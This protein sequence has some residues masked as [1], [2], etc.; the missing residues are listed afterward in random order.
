[1]LLASIS[2]VLAICGAALI[3]VFATSGVSIAEQRVAL[4]IGNGAY[5]HTTTLKNPSNDAAAIA[6][7]L[8]RLG[9]KVLEGRDLT[10]A[11]FRDQLSDFSETLSQ[12]ETALFFYAGHAIQVDL[13][14]W[15]IPV[16]AQIANAIDLELRAISL[17]TILATME[18]SARVRL[19]FL[20][21]CRDNPMTIRLAKELGTRSMS[22]GRGLARI[23]VGVGTLIAYST[24]LGAVAADGDGPHSPFTSSLLA[25][26]E[27]PDLE[28]RQLL[29]RVRAQVVEATKQAQVPWDHSSLM[30]DFYLA[31]GAA[32]QQQ[33][34]AA[35]RPSPVPQ[36]PA[37]PEP[38]AMSGPGVPEPGSYTGSVLS[39]AANKALATTVLG[40]HRGAIALLTTA[41]QQDPN[42]GLLYV[43]RGRSYAGLGMCDEAISDLNRAKDF[44][45]TKQVLWAVHYSIAV[46][47]SDMDDTVAEA[48]AAIDLYPQH[49]DMYALR[50]AGHLTKRRFKQAL[51]D[52]NTAIQLEPEASEHYA[53]R[54]SVQCLGGDE[55][56]GK[57][58]MARA[59]SLAAGNAEALQALE[60]YAK[61]CE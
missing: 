35:V 13:E 52:A 60:I 4:V 31:G 30:S 24:Q 26:I 51:A 42:D 15:L 37:Q 23:D 8:T 6:A 28:I 17:R 5:Q 29:T 53:L 2:R 38:A 40:D 3:F 54:A 12:A 14:N 32:G 18:R 21:A 45:L 56:Q 47:S 27:L 48:T 19:V 25:H 36:L 10:R 59:R 16:D 50:S 43:I 55:H 44:A 20:D 57:V 61:E 58:D 33:M 41:L 7:A 9:F 39:E 34:A 11:G 1:M 22:V 49:P 46:C